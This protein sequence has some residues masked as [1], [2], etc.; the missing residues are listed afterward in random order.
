MGMDACF[1]TMDCETDNILLAP[2]A[3]DKVVGVLCPLDDILLQDD[4][5]MVCIRIGSVYP[6]LPKA[7]LY[8]TSWSPLN[9]MPTVQFG[10]FF[11]TWSGC[12]ASI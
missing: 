9:I 7:R 3:T 1:V 5:A 4:V 12:L 8:S 10:L 6:W 2:F 11:D